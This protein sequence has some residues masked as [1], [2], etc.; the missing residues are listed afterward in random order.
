MNSNECDDFVS[1]EKFCVHGIY[2]GLKWQ[3]IEFARRWLLLCK[4]CIFQN[5]GYAADMWQELI[6]V[7]RVTDGQKFPL[8]TYSNGS[9][10][11]PECGSL[12]I[13]LRSEDS[14]YSHV[15]VICKVQE[16]FIRVC[17]QNYQFHYWSSNYA[18]QIPMIY[19]NGLYYIEDNYDVYG[20]A[21]DHDYSSSYVDNP[22]EMFLMQSND[23]N[24]CYYKANEDFFET[25]SSTSN[26]L[27]QLFMQATDYIIHN[28]E[29]LTL[30][31][32]PNQ[33]WLRIRRSWIDERDS[34][35]ALTM[36][37]SAVAQ[38]KWAQNMNLDYDF[39]SSFQ[40]HCLLVMKEAG[41]DSKLC[42]LPNDLYWQDSIIVDKDGEIINNVWKLWDWEMIF[43]NFEDRYRN[44]KEENE[45]ESVNNERPCISD[46]LLN[47]QIRIIELLWKSITNHT[48]FLSILSTMLSNHPNISHNEWISSENST[49]IPLVNG[50]MEEQNNGI[51]MSYDENKSF[52]ID[53]NIEEYSDYYDISQKILSEK[54]H[55]NSEKNIV[56]WMIHGICSGFSMCE[57][58][59][60]ITDTNNSITYCCII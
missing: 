24:I 21:F 50:S 25:I 60:H 42:L 13:Y 36:L 9:L 28:D 52:I 15:A 34:N 27:Y 3:C 48:A 56:S 44:Y 16:S 55:E 45:W 18:R 57:D 32:I 46:I 4:S 51:V 19:R 58:Q 59:N 35:R 29:F 37:Q 33:F 26:Q 20:W 47:E 10:Y 23:K 41:M 12:L 2:T 39:T 22:K 1:F 31:K 40:L 8:K 54:N 43:Q 11:K 14:P 38:E 6:Y 17:E 5:I 30:F 7:E 53:D 49:H